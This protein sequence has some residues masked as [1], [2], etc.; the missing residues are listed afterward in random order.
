LGKIT[1]EENKILLNLKSLA[2]SISSKRPVGFKGNL[3]KECFIKSSMGP[4]F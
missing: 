3:F 2:E 4:S 1:F